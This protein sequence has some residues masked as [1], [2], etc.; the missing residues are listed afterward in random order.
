M[1]ARSAQL[2]AG[3]YLISVEREIVDNDWG[4]LG[5]LLDAALKRVLDSRSTGATTGPSTRRGAV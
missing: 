4:Q 2:P 1:R 3:W 5:T